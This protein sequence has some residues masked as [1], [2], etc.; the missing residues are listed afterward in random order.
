MYDS[1][2]SACKEMDAF[3]LPTA[4]AQFKTDHFIFANVSFLRATGLTGREISCLALSAV[5]K[6]HLDSV[7][8]LKRAKIAPIAVRSFDRNLSLGGFAAF[9]REGLVYL[10]IPSAPK[11]NE[12]FEM[13]K[14]VGLESERQ[15]V[16][17]YLHERLAPELLAVAFSVE[18]VRYQLEQEKHSAEPE[19]KEVCR[20]LSELLGSMHEELLNPAPRGGGPPGSSP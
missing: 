9:N 16:S 5:A 6:F 4:V 10:M 11:T 12:A 15:R 13:G 20:E 14:A 3:A 19:V 7:S 8:T 2:I 17:A 18:A 1:I